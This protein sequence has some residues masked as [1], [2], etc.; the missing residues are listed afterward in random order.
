MISKEDLTQEYISLVKSYHPE[1]RH[2]LD[3]CYIKVI[4]GYIPKLRKN[5][6]YIGIY[7]PKK[8]LNYLIKHQDAFKEIADNMGLIEV[9]SIDANRLI[10]DPMLKIKREDP[11]LWLEIYWIATQEN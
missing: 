7:Y 3:R 10:K 1:T 4:D 6:Y 11:R 5:F 8:L 9:V 2:L